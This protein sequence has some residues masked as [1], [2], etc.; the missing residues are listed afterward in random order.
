MDHEVDA[1]RWDFF[2]V[3]N[4]FSGEILQPGLLKKGKGW[5]I[6][7]MAFGEIFIKK[8]PYLKKKELKSR[9]N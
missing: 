2:F 9:Q 3:F 4:F 1:G 5:R 7:Q 6:Q 8:S